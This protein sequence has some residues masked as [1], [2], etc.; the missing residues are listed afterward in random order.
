MVSRY[1]CFSSFPH[2]S[3]FKF[4]PILP[5]LLSF[6]IGSSYTRWCDSL[7]SLW[8]HL[9]LRILL[10]RGHRSLP[11]TCIFFVR[12]QCCYSRRCSGNVVKTF[13]FKTAGQAMQE[14]NSGLLQHHHTLFPLCF[15]CPSFH[16]QSFFCQCTIMLSMQN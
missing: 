9:S 8:H 15:T 6:F 10:W 14:T 3:D 5:L 4:I 16:I 11:N 7:Y 12:S 2:L 13:A 1:A